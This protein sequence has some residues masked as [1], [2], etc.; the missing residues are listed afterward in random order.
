MIVSITIHFLKSAKTIRHVLFVVDMMKI[1]VNILSNE[2][3]VHIVTNI[4]RK[5]VV[6]FAKRFRAKEDAIF[7]INATWMIVLAMRIVLDIKNNMILKNCKPKS[8]V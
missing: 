5:I 1:F 6:L 3:N 2:K 7:G 8:F 4:A